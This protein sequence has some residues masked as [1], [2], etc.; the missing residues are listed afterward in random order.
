MI[1]Y[2]FEQRCASRTKFN[3]ISHFLDKYNIDIL[4]CPKCKEGIMHRIAELPRSRGDPCP[5]R[6]SSSHSKSFVTLAA[7]S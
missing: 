1:L 4:K 6:S 7:W 3:P 2:F 5:P